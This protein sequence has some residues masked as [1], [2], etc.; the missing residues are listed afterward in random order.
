MSKATEQAGNLLL[1]SRTFT[2]GNLGAMK[3]T[4]GGLP[5]DVQSQILR[6][7]GAEELQAANSYGRRKAMAIVAMDIGLNYLSNSI[8]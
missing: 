6:D 5:R 3:D 2:L 8:L 4:I 1:F 7:A